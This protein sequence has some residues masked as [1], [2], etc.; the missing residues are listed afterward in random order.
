MVAEGAQS[1]AA[2]A[3][4]GERASEGLIQV[5]WRLRAIIVLLSLVILALALG[6]WLWFL[7]RALHDPVGR[8]DFSSYYAAA[9]ALRGNPHADIYSA[10]VMARSG[11]ANHVQVQPPLPYTYPPLLAIALV[12]LTLV[13]F[14]IAARLWLLLNATS[15]LACALLLAQELR[16]RFAGIL[17]QVGALPAAAPSRRWSSLLIEPAPVLALA[18]SAALFLPFAPAEQTVLLGQIDL[19]VLLPLAAVP[20][21]TRHGHERWVG[22][23]IAV[24]AMLKLTPALLLVYLV[25]R[26]RWAALITGLVVLAALALVS[27]AVVGPAV[28]FTALPEALRVGSGDAALGHNEALFAPIVAVVT[29]A[30]PVLAGAARV[31]EYALLAALAVAVGWVL[32]RPTRRGASSAGEVIVS[33]AVFAAG[34]ARGYAVALCAMVL[35]SPAAW[36]HHYVWVL[37]AAALVI[38]MADAKA[39][40]VLVARAHAVARR[41]ALIRLGVTVAGCCLLGWMLPYN[42]DTEP[43][44]GTSTLFGLPVRPLFLEFRPLGALLILIVATTFAL[45]RRS[46]ASQE[47]RQAS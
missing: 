32:W 30:T 22:G 11:A 28:F 15:W 13:P 34:E 42:W 10:A 24:A 4:D 25:L 27:A 31:V 26:R 41:A 39:L 44:P 3:R 17:S 20:W 14:N 12:P 7:W 38:G 6:S 5:S 40:R 2:S 23:A 21:L 1:A 9:A 36:V 37:P 47:D 43:R 8:Y 16:L 33:R 45:Q 19:M 46:P 35:L 29:G 18:V